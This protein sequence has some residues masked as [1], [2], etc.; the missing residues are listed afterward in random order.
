MKKKDRVLTYQQARELKWFMQNC[1]GIRQE[2]YALL[3]KVTAFGRHVD[4]LNQTCL[5][6]EEFL[7]D[8]E[9]KDDP[10]A[11]APGYMGDINGPGTEPDVP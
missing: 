7:R 1:T 4:R 8:W 9:L 10:E 2:Y 5:Q 6:I 3:E 11:K